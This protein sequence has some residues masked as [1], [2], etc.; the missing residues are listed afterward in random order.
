M[1]SVFIVSSGCKHEGGGIVA[2]FSSPTLACLHAEK[3]VAEKQKY[4]DESNDELRERA[5]EDELGLYANVVANTGK[6]AYESLKLDSWTVED[7]GDAVAA[8]GTS[9]DYV[10]VREYAIDAVQP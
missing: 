6:D 7:K 3:L 8:W 9:N 4:V 1:T 2:V 10:I 5:K